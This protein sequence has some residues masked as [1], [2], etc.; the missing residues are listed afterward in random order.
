MIKN[1]QEKINKN[2]HKKDSHLTK[3]LIKRLI[4]I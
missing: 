1:H 4:K 2:P 3:K